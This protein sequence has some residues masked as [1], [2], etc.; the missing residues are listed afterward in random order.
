MTPISREELA[1]LLRAAATKP[2]LR[3]ELRFVPGEISDWESR[4]FLTVMN[5]SQSEGVMIAPLDILRVISFRL[6][7]RAANSSGRV[8]A[9]ICDICATWQRGTNSAAV[10]FQKGGST[11]SFLCCRDLLC[12]LHVR[13]KTPQAQLSRAQLREDI[14]PEARILR[15]KERL[16][17]ILESANA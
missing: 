10:T 2:R 1:V 6:D 12:S 15:L 9:V 8:E 5:R 17:S 11:V 16:G 7:K 3:R 13:G 14:T 4:D